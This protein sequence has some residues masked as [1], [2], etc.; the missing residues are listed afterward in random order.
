ME[1]SLLQISNICQVNI[2]DPPS[3]RAALIY[4]A[5]I[6][7]VWPAFWTVGM[8][9]DWPAHGEIDIIENINEQTVNQETLHTNSGCNITKSLQQGTA[10]GDGVCD[11]FFQDPP[12]QYQHQGC[13]V[14]DDLPVNQPSYGTPFNNLGGGVYVM[15]STRVL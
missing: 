2:S 7:G 8:P 9:P 15:V 3:I 12:N 4:I 5:S 11:E 13:S 14:S 10:N 1:G 6:C